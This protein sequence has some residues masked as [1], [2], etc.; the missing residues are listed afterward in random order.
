MKNNLGSFSLKKKKKKTTTNQLKTEVLGYRLL[1]FFF[2]KQLYVSRANSTV[3][4]N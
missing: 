4:I 2:L 1:L 3:T